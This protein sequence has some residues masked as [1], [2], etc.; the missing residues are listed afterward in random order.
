[1]RDWKE[2][3]WLTKFEL[4]TF[5]RNLLGLAF[6]FI[7]TYLL[8]RSTIPSYLE[9]PSMGL[10]FFFSF[11]FSG[12]L[13]QLARSKDYQVQKFRSIHYASPFLTALNQLAINKKIIVKYRFLTYLALLTGFNGLLLIGFY[14]EFQTEMGLSNYLAFACIWFCFG[15]YIGCVGPAFEPGSNLGWTIFYS[16]F[17]ATALFILYIQLFYK[18]YKNG[19]VTWTIDIANQYPL[20]SIAISVILSIIGWKFWMKIMWT[21]M[22]N[23]DYL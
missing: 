5:L 16:L 11:T 14:P 17:I 1:M 22:K 10:D 21:R 18:W 23:T 20:Y 15:I 19:L 4:R 8:I 3:I 12:F 6:V 9:E 13:S 7:L 2:A